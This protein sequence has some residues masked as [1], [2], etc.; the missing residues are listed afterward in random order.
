MDE[1]GQT[2]GGQAGAGDE[3]TLG[4]VTEAKEFCEYIQCVCAKA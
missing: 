1:A 4:L 3:G 2:E